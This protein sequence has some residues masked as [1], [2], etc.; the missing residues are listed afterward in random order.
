MRKMKYKL[1]IKTNGE[2]LNLYTLIKPYCQMK[3]KITSVPKSKTA[4]MKEWEKAAKAPKRGLP[5]GI[6]DFS[7][8]YQKAVYYELKGF[9]FDSPEALQEIIGLM[10]P[11]MSPL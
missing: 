10:E 4:H 8:Y 11:T 1:N 9:E 6:Y 3:P 7:D 5:P 2:K